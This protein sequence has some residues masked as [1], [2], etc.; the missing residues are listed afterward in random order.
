MST[1]NRSSTEWAELQETTEASLRDDLVRIL[2]AE[3]VLDDE[4]QRRFHATDIY[5]GDKVPALVIRPGTTEELAA[6]TRVVTAAGFSII[7]RGGGTSYT[8]GIVPERETSVIA[9][10]SGLICPGG[11][12]SL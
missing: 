9:D 10:T 4:W 8:G 6:A 11:E 3:R 2:G 7:G 12:N 5:A 1:D